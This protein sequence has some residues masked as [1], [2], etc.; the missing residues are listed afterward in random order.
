M[1]WHHVEGLTPFNVLV[2]HWWR[3][4]PAFMGRPENALKLAIL[5]LRNLPPAQRD[6]WK[7]IF[8]H[9]IFDHQPGDL[10][11][12]P[13]AVKGMLS[14]PLDLLSAKKIRAELLNKLKV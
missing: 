5:S 8:E 12:I 10:D 13:D 7:A 14:Q 6:A 4:T 3:D 2:T 1:W 11:H 9:Y